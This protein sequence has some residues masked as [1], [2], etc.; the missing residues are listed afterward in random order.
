MKLRKY[1]WTIPF[2]CVL[3]S[4]MVLASN[5]VPALTRFSKV[6][7]P[8][9]PIAYQPADTT[10]I[11]SNILDKHLVTNILILLMMAAGSVLG[12]FLIAW[13]YCVIK[14]RRET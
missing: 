1:W 8:Q 3:L 5:K 2:A 9:P 13:A 7:S 12:A 6:P 14:D 10:I 4:M 11:I